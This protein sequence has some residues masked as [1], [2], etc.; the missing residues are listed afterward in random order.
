MESH[1]KLSALSFMLQLLRKGEGDNLI[2]ESHLE[3]VNP[4][5]FLV[6][7]SGPGDIVSQLQD[8]VRVFIDPDLRL[9]LSQVS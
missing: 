3:H 5:A 4:H 6:L 7:L 9:Y 1:R 8:F 2:A